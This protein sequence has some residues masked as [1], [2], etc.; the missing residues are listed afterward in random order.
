MSQFPVRLLLVLFLAFAFS[1]A[2]LRRKEG[3]MGL[4][5]FLVWAGVWVLAA[6][7]IIRPDFTT[8]IAKSIGIGRGADV[9]IYLSILIIFY[10]LFRVHI[11]IENLHHEITKV[12]REMALGEIGKGKK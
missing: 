11:M 6:A 9:I 10:L 1:R 3:A 4:G 12:V 8:Y 2:I 5:S 7:G